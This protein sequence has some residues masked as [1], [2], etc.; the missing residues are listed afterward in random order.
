MKKIFLAILAAAICTACTS[1]SEKESARQLKEAAALPIEKEAEV[2]AAADS[3]CPVE[4]PFKSELANTTWTPTFLANQN[5]APMPKGGEDGIVFL[6]FS[7]DLKVNGMSGDNLCGG[8][9][10]IGRNGSFRAARMFSTRRM[11]PYSQ[12]EYKFLQAIHKANRIYIAASGKK[13]KLMD[14]KE[15]LIEFKKIPNIEK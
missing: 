12:Y 5:N 7:E 8:D 11:G 13:M 10:I 6:H 3:A 14:E 15:V 9:F 1:T 4:E 2:A